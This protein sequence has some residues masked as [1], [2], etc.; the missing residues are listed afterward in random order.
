MPEIQRLP[1][2]KGYLW[3]IAVQIQSLTIRICVTNT[4]VTYKKLNIRD[5][6]SAAGNSC[7]G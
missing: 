5:F 2:R 6:I 4:K 7:S 1:L 3:E